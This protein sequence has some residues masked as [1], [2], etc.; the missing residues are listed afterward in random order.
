MA[1][2]AKTMVNDSVVS[3]GPI[4]DSR[5]IILCLGSGGVGKTTTAAA[6]G[7]AAA[8]AGKRALCLTID[9]ARRLAQSL[10]LSETKVEA[11]RVA[12][13][14]LR[15]AG[16]KAKGSLAVMILDTKRTFDDLIRRHASSAAVRDRILKNRF[17]RYVSTSLGGTREY[18][19]VE[20]VFEIKDDPAWDV[21]I[22]D[23]PPTPNAL[24]FLDA[25]ERLIAALDSVIIRWLI[26]AFRSSRGGLNLI[27]RGAA[28]AL[29]GLGKITGQGFLQVT[30]EFLVT[31]EELFAGFRKRADEVK[32]ALRSKDVA[33][34]LVTSPDPMSVRET[35]F[36][37]DRLRQLRMPRSAI[38]VNRVHVAPAGS[39]SPEQVR[40]ELKRAGLH[41][42][43]AAAE[44]VLR[45]LE[46]QKRWAA[47]D[48]A[49]LEILAGSLGK[50]IP[51]RVDVPAFAGD[52]HDIQTLTRVAE[53]LV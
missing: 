4:L 24:D 2:A 22:L 14:R 41:L 26:A 51:V 13:A 19:A 1:L 40:A 34:V 15:E 39:P 33:C 53:A 6:L 45:A 47:L 37:C 11:Q 42:G 28:A 5:R 43:P 23:T 35:L 27:A 9:P 3:L 32:R 25:P 49:H 29:R 7:L 36:L 46:D 30:A 38:V 48:R 52:V 10:G 31:T 16:L 21:I 8:A 20:K 50:R 44:R 18:M 12:P 17:Y